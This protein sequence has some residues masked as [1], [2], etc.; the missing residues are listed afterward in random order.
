MT[1]INNKPPPSLTRTQNAEQAAPTTAVTKTTAIKETAPVTDSLGPKVPTEPREVATIAAGPAEVETAL[2]RVVALKEHPLFG[3]GPNAKPG[4]EVN[5]PPGLDLSAQIDQR[6]VDSLE[7]DAVDPKLAGTDY[8]RALLTL[9]EELP[10]KR[11]TDLL[12]KA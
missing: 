6:M 3:D 4:I 2:R 7:A 11:F 5:P 1:T 12:V 8:Q 10:N 9:R